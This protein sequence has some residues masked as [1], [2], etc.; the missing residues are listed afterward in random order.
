MHLMCCA[1]RIAGNHAQGGDSTS[2]KGI[3]VVERQLIEPL[4]RT[5]EEFRQRRVVQTTLTLNDQVEEIHL[6]LYP[7]PVY[8]KFLEAVWDEDAVEGS[9]SI[10]NAKAAEMIREKA[11][12]LNS[13]SELS[14]KKLAT[15]VKCLGVIMRRHELSRKHRRHMVGGKQVPDNGE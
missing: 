1:Q 5:V 13:N 6:L 2:Q 12:A 8:K 9:L 15:I 10:D 11:A 3:G 4:P 14:K 7:D